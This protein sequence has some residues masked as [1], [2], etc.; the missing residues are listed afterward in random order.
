MVSYYLYVLK[1]DQDGTSYTTNF[2]AA[3]S[4]IFGCNHVKPVAIGILAVV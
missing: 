4:E 1:H 3:S 2:L